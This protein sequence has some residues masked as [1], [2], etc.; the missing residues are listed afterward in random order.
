MAEGDPIEAGNQNQITIN[1]ETLGEFKD[2][3]V[4]KPFEGKDISEVFKPIIADRVI[5]KLINKK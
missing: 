2:D 1:A 3:P 5:F 4:F